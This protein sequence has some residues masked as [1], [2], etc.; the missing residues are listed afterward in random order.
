MG[1]LLS[2]WIIFVM[3]FATSSTEVT[4]NNPSDLTQSTSANATKALEQLNI[5]LK[6]PGAQ[7]FRDEDFAMTK[8]V[9]DR[10]WSADCRHSAKTTDGD[11]VCHIRTFEKYED[12]V[13]LEFIYGDASL[14]SF[15]QP[16]VSTKN[17]RAH[18]EVVE[19][20][21]DVEEHSGEI[22]ILHR[23][24]E[25]SH[26]AVEWS[27]VVLRMEI[28]G[29]R[30]VELT[31]DKECGYGEHEKLD[32]GW[33]AGKG[34]GDLSRPM[35]LKGHVGDGSVPTF[36]PRT[37]STRVYMRLVEEGLSQQFDRPV[38][39]ARGADGGV[40][41]GVEVRGAY[42]G[43]VV[44]GRGYSIFDVIYG[45][46]GKGVSV[47]TVSVRVLP[48]NTM[49]MQWRKDCGGGVAQGL[50]VGTRVGL[51]GNRVVADVVK[52]GVSIGGY[53]YR[54]QNDSVRGYS[55]VR[56]RGRHGVRKFYVWGGWDEIGEVSAHVEDER[57]ASGEG[58]IVGGVG[59][60]RKVLVWTRCRKKGVTR[61][62]VTMSVR[63]REA[64]EWWFDEICSRERM[65]GGRGRG[66]T[67]GM[68]MWWTM[69]MF[70]GILGLWM[71]RMVSGGGGVGGVGVGGGGGGVGDSGDG[72][73]HMQRRKRKLMAKC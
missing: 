24:E 5:I 13:I 20:S 40:Q 62:G 14:Y 17:G 33:F 57:I 66:M 27:E 30:E 39:N 11:Y 28:G 46:E 64:V 8:G 21:N 42:F 60:V 71:R 47:V 26:R 16:V 50:D 15:K 69:G 48:F 37:L 29:G 3:L 35:S 68:V 4:D 6:T 44:V 63:D 55:H 59:E 58:E 32:Y 72:D 51:W 34:A 22:T 43:G 2:T 65:K 38:V 1:T 61:I 18:P 31:W 67:A 7:R 52:N 19:F 45:C 56:H 25:V 23:C 73:G 36:G 49:Y 10:R 9:A 41:V 70:V 12:Q 54:G 53:G